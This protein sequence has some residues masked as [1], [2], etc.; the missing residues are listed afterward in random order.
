[1]KNPDLL[2]DLLS[3]IDNNGKHNEKSKSKIK[4]I[5]SVTTRKYNRLLDIETKRLHKRLHKK[6]TYS[7]PAWAKK[8]LINDD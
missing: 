2:T 3:M 6:L 7:L 5:K 8:K 1:M 4:N